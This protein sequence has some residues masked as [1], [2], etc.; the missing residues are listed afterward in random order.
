MQIKSVSLRN[1]RQFIDPVSIRDFGPGLNLLTASNEAGKSTFFDALHAAFYFPHRSWKQKEAK[2]LEP[3]S[4]G[5]PEV[6]VAFDYDGAV[7]KIGKRWSSSAARRQARLW[8]DDVLVAQ[9]G[10]AEDRLAEILGASAEGGP[11]GLLW[12]R[13]GVVEMSERGEEQDARRGIMDSVAGEVEAMTGGRRMEEALN[14]VRKAIDAEMTTRGPKRGS[15]LERLTGEV[16]YL[17]KEQSRLQ[18]LVRRQES[19]LELRRKLRLELAELTDPESRHADEQAARKAAQDLEAAKAHD[20]K[21]KAAGAS[22]ASQEAKRDS[23]QGAID[24]LS[25][26]LTE[27]QQAE[28]AQIQA[29]E[30]F[31]AGQQALADAETRL[32]TARQDDAAADQEQRACRDMRDRI[33]KAQAAQAARSRRTDLE[34]RIADAEALR[35]RTETLDAEIAQGLSAKAL[36]ALE[37]HE[38]NLNVAIRA[39]DR[40]AASFT[41]RYEAESVGRIRIGGAPVDG[42]TAR[43]ITETT[44]LDIDGIGA[45]ELRPPVGAGDESVE[46]ARVVLQEALTTNGF[47]DMAAARVS[48][49]KRA[50]DEDVLRGLTAQFAAIAPDGIDALRKALAV[51]PV[52]GEGVENLPALDAAEAALDNA[53]V[54]R[55]KSGATLRE[56]QTAFDLADKA[57][58]RLEGAATSAGERLVR[59]TTALGAHDDPVTDLEQMRAE[60]ATLEDAVVAARGALTALEAQAPDLR[61]AEAVAQRTASVLEATRTRV[62]ALERQLAELNGAIGQRGSEGIEEELETVSGQLAARRTRLEKLQFDIRANKRLLKALEDAQARA[63]NRHVAPVVQELVP[64]LRLIWPDADPVVNAETGM[65]TSV[66]RRAVEEDFDVLSGGTREQ[67]SLLVRLAFARILA[68]EGRPAPV[69]LDDAIVY[70]D[71]ERIEQMFN[72]L[73][74]QAQDVQIIVFSCRQRAF[75]ALGGTPLVISREDAA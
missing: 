69:I 19:D 10:E 75:R 61:A 51:L 14:A 18:D 4:G 45:L 60:V 64:L 20:E 41:V 15:E 38:A 70:T 5:D 39:R 22:L 67:I 36:A 43:S 34:K 17:G 3:R 32:G 13:Q 27:K 44:V 23:V 53:D 73:T 49:V 16:D 72:A 35:A 68:R 11:A 31:K 57:F 8:K 58:A 2:Q 28:E 21:V 1:V 12:V 52:T 48:A 7:W 50:A 74:Q 63:R 42:D 62:A 24:A 56:A 6:E 59:A 71:D 26:K 30:A 66:T 25:L 65:I 55:A 9:A 40:A 33:L 29:A 37:A 54:V 47:E 46:A